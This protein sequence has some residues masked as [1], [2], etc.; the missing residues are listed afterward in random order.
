MLTLLTGAGSRPASLQS[1]KH[2][3]LPPLIHF[4][5]FPLNLNAGGNCGSELLRL[6]ATDQNIVSSNLSTPKLGF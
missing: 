3:S 4:K 6:W 5:H 2:S 1:F